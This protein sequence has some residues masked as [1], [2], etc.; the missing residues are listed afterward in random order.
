MKKVILLALCSMLTIGFSFVSCDI[1]SVKLP[2]KASGDVVKVTVNAVANVSLDP[3]YEITNL[4][5]IQV[6]FD[7][8]KGDKSFTLYRTTSESGLAG[9]AI[10]GFDLHPGETITVKV[11]SAANVTLHGDPRSGDRSW[12]LKEEE[13]SI[14]YSTVK[15]ESGERGAYTWV[16][17]FTLPLQ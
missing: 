5:G 14:D 1:S 3:G 13:Q 11:K 9:D 8:N 7:F 6:R 10:V 12:W 16:A 17:R 15:A 2:S 4:S